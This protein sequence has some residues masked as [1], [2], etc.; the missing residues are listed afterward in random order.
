LLRG[1]RIEINAHYGRAFAREAPC[2][3][4]ADGATCAGDECGLVCKPSHAA[5]PVTTC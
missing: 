1:A 3:R 5:Q 2:D 4:A